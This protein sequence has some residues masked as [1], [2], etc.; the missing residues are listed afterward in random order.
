MG[1]LV[2]D[3]Q[4][5][6]LVDKYSISNPICHLLALLGSHH[7]LHVSGVRVNHTAGRPCLYISTIYFT[8]W[9]KCTRTKHLLYAFY[10]KPTILMK[11]SLSGMKP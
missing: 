5:H 2:Q 8:R 11:Q 1:T 6:I 10:F 3:A 9:L 7:I 4:H